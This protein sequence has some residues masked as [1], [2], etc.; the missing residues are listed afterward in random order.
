LNQ[1]HQT[2]DKG[3]PAR[4][5]LQ[6]KHH[7]DPNGHPEHQLMLVLEVTIPTPLV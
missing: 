1:L 4:L 3:A 7:R 2:R 6:V 5:V